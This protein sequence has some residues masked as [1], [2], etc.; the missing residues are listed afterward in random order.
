MS[1]KHLV[2]GLGIA[3]AFA[4]NAGASHASP[5]DAPGAKTLPAPGAGSAGSGMTSQPP[6]HG[7]GGNNP[8]SRSSTTG[9]GTSIDRSSTTG[10]RSGS[11]NVGGGEKGSKG[12]P[13]GSGAPGT[14]ATQPLGKTGQ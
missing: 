12:D 11:G 10:Q 6:D 2:I 5:N 8:G 9:Q 13:T 14:G 1:T 4:M 7:I 3:A